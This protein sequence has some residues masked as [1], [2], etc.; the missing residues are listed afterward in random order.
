MPDISIIIPSYNSER[1][2]AA[3]LDSV[4]GQSFS[5]WECIVVDDGSSDDSSGHARRYAARDPRFKYIRQV[6]SGRA[7]AC[8]TGYGAAAEESRYLFFLDSDDVL[9][10]NALEVLRNYLESNPAVGVVGCQFQVIDGNGHDR[11]PGYRSRWVP[12]WP[13]PRLLKDSEYDTPFV[14]FYCATGQGPYAMIRRA[15]YEK[16]TGFEVTLSPF[17]CHEDTDIF[18]QLAL[19]SRVHYIPARLYLKRDHGD[20]VSQ[21]FARISQSYSV[22]RKKW[23][24]YKPG[25]A[26]EAQQL[27][28]ARVFYYH[29]F[30]P[31]RN[32]KV[33]FKA[34]GEALA[35]R[36]LEKLRWSMR[37]FLEGVAGLC[38]RWG[39]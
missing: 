38:G 35:A 12:G 30:L 4:I 11:G 18:C 27:E 31:L 14:T 19:K 21:S 3:T 9:S 33:G 32:F 1:F 17:S 28:S 15:A 8:N 24:S 23:D 36:S 13:L 7:I 25:S 16:T 2:L 34:L 10:S 22:F 26:E 6:N 5:D 20:N 37:L 29:R 39:G